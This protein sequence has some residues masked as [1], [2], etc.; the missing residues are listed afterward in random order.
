LVWNYT[1]YSKI[2]WRKRLWNLISTIYQ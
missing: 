2:I 1:V